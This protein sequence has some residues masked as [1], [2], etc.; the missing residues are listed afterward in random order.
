MKEHANVAV[1][2]NRTVYADG[3]VGPARYYTQLLGPIDIW[4]EEPYGS[5]AYPGGRV[6][7][8]QRV[9]VDVVV[10]DVSCIVEEIVIQETYPAGFG[11]AQGSRIV[12]TFGGATYGYPAMREWITF[13]PQITVYGIGG[14][15]T[16][17][18][19]DISVGG[20]TSALVNTVLTWSYLS[21]GG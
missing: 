11:Q 21:S 6:R 8:A 17:D 10:Q 2:A 3:T 7:P 18:A 14:V 19:A 20:F 12:S 1:S 5:T 15:P 16:Q 13:A 9:R 4:T